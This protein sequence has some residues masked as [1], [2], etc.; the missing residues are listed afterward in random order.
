MGLTAL[1]EPLLALGAVTGI[2]VGLFQLSRLW[3]RLNKDKP[4]T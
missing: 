1:L 3:N 2:V 4:D